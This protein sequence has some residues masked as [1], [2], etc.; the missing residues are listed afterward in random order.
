MEEEKS[1]GE[2]WECNLY[3]E[4]VKKQSTA[5]LHWVQGRLP[6][7]QKTWKFWLENEMVRTI[8]FETFPKL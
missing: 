6:F 8:P 5:S 4:V 1:Y 3:F 2:L 7:T